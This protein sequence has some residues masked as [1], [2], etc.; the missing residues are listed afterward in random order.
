MMSLPFALACF[1]R[2]VNRRRLIALA[3]VIELTAGIHEV[4]IS[5]FEAGGGGALSAGMRAP[6]GEWA[7]LDG[8]DFIFEAYGCGVTSSTVVSWTSTFLAALVR[9]SIHSFVHKLEQPL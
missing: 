6:G 9:L 8:T 2:S 1:V 7:P 4:T 3:G 5:F